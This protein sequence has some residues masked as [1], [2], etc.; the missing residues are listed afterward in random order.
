[1]ALEFDT[2]SF[3]KA[4]DLTPTGD[5]SE[6]GLPLVQNK[7][8]D[9]GEF[10]VNAAMQ[11]V[12]PSVDLKSVKAMPMNSPDQ[13]IPMSPVEWGDRAKIQVGNRPGNLD[14]LKSRFQDASYDP[15]LG[16]VIQDKGV[17]KQVDPSILDIKD[18]WEASKEL[19]KDISTKGLDI[20]ASVGAQIGASAVLGPIAGAVAGGAG[21]SYLRSSLGRLVGTYKPSSDTEEMADATVEALSNLAFLGAGKAVKAFAV[22]AE[23]KVEAM[24]QAM[25]KI[26]D[27]VK[28]RWG[29]VIPDLMAH[30][31]S[32][33]LH[34][35]PEAAKRLLSDA[36]L[37]AKEAKATL[38]QLAESMGAMA[39]G[40][41]DQAV[42]AIPKKMGQVVQQLAEGSGK[43]GNVELQPMFNSMVSEA[44]QQGIF[45]SKKVGNSTVAMFP[46]AKE[47]DAMRAAGMQVLA[48]SEETRSALTPLLHFMNERVLDASSHSGSKGA[49]VLMGIKQDLRQIVQKLPADLAQ[50]IGAP[51]E[52]KMNTIV[53]EKFT[54]AGLA[55]LYS[56][57]SQQL[58]AYQGMDQ[59]VKQMLG[60]A[61]GPHEFVRA[62][63]DQDPSAQ[64]V[65]SMLPT[66]LVEGMKRKAAAME[67][68][69]FLPNSMPKWMSQ[70]AV[71]LGVAMHM[72]KVPMAI[73]MGIMSPRANMLMQAAGQGVTKSKPV[74]LAVEGARS[75]AD[76][77]FH[78]TQDVANKLLSDPTSLS[79]FGAATMSGVGA[80][81]NASKQADSMIQKVLK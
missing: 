3:L 32:S 5:L 2:P 9:V 80:Y 71:G 27:A 53:G 47:V 8:G 56:S 26:G 4:N 31:Y 37:I 46:S 29:G 61:K 23:P 51:L 19:A 59:G 76:F 38:P 45:V 10:D 63:M 78:T 17:W 24:S 36:P 49:A 68:H 30:T 33:V 13:A 14:L 58:R 43:L 28:E 74:R 72:P 35:T 11:H 70:S 77:A 67:L 54:Q 18:P 15:K 7:Q 21:A 22:G 64:Q 66:P 62:L 39:K 50:T 6:R 69:S 44:A 12:D 79:Q 20:A 55:D 25:G 40:G 65:A 48:L 52:Q 75:A 16:L 1:M 34:T 60:S 57:A 41:L 73:I 42:V 81:Q